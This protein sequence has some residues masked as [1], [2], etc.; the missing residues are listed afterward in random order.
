MYCSDEAYATL[1]VPVAGA[2]DDADAEGEADGL[3]AGA[4]DAGADDEE[5]EEDDE[6]LQPAAS[7]M[8]TMP[9][10]AAN[11]LFGDLKGSIP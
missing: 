2:E 8:L 11:R 9:S 6:L 3:V 1:T 4:D 5:E 7:A 10:R